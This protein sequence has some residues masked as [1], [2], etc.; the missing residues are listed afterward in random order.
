MVSPPFLREIDSVLSQLHGAGE[1]IDNDV[2]III[3]ELGIN[4]WD[5]AD[6]Y[7]HTMEALIRSLLACLCPSSIFPRYP[8]NRISRADPKAPAVLFAEAFTIFL[9][10]LSTG[11]DMHLGLANY[12]D[13]PL[14][15]TR[16]WLLQPIL[17]NDS[18][19]D[20]YFFGDR[21]VQILRLGL[22]EVL[23]LGAQGWYGQAQ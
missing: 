5:R 18:L 2:D 15:S 1:H 12:Y 22:I 3:V 13:T 4:D 10:Q 19:K 17:E 11:A 8:L 9:P 20:V 14:L 21:S 7:F 6:R 16:N 23:T